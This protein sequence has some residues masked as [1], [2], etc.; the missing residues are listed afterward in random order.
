MD[1]RNMTRAQRLELVR[2]AEE[3][4][5]VKG[6]PPQNVVDVSGW[7]SIGGGEFNMHPTGMLVHGP[8]ATEVIAEAQRSGRGN[9][10]LWNVLTAYLR[11]FKEPQLYHWRGPWF[12]LEASERMDDGPAAA[13]LRSP[14]TQ[15]TMN[16]IKTAVRWMVLFDGNGYLVK[17][18][19][20]GGTIQDNTTG[21]LAAV[22]PVSPARMWP[23]VYDRSDP[24]FPLS[25]GWIDYYAYKTGKGRPH[26]IPPENVIHFRHIPNP[27]DPRLG[28][29]TVREIVR[30]IATDNEAT[31]LMNAVLSNLG[32]PG[33]LVTPRDN[34]TIPKEDRGDLK[35]SI[36]SRTTGG[37]RG[38]PIVM[39][40]PVDIEQFNIN[41]RQYD[42]AHVWGHVETRIAGAIGWPAILAGLSAGL[43]AATYNNTGG[44]REYATE[45]ILI[46]A[47]VDDGETWTLGLRRDFGLRE[48]EW[49]GYAYNRVRALQEDQNALWERTGSAWE[50]NEI[51]IG[52]HHGMLN[53][54]LPAGVNPNA[55]K[56]DIEGDADGGAP[57]VASSAS[58]ADVA[59]AQAIVRPDTVLNGAQVE[60]AKAIIMDVAA[61]VLPKSAGSTM[62]EVF[63]NL[64][65]PIVDELMANLDDVDTSGLGAAAAALIGGKGRRL[66]QVKRAA[67]PAP[68]VTEDDV[69]DAVEAWDAWAKDNA[70]E[71]EGILG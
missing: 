71:F 14:N 4:L 43:D 24:R 18:R 23:A 1:T 42:L 58:S 36:Q 60:A 59:E 9:S 61:G 52:Q 39:S 25:N 34:A 16:Q 54:E 64:P 47:W 6:T 7:Y 65:R 17:Q 10:V 62:L 40:K 38:E 56:V 50:R 28:M 41:L 5:G 27:D 45:D 55:R 2:R 29:K 66:L 13:F 3:R 32:V 20:G 21:A 44:L 22:W 57:P 68:E 33:I 67:L 37:R 12:D 26:E 11:A 35:A 53:L 69:L 49:I 30:E 70:P 63:F 48:D 31:A 46:A 8:G 51:T 15:L 19:T